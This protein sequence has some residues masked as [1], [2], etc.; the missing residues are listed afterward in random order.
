MNRFNPIDLYAEAR[1]NAVLQL[2]REQ[3]TEEKKTKRGKEEKVLQNREI[4]SLGG[5]FWKANGL[6][7]KSLKASE[8]DGKSLNF[9]GGKSLNFL[10]EGIDVMFFL[11]KPSSFSCLQ[12]YPLGVELYLLRVV[13]L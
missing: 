3:K 9:S 8:L 2:S 1:D 13:F 7:I 10:G 11:E 6:N 4:R 5:K 12:R